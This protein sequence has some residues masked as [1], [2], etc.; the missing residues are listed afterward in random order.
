[1]TVTVDHVDPVAR[2]SCATGSTVPRRP[3]QRQLPGFSLQPY[4]RKLLRP[5]AVGRTDS[6]PGPERELMPLRRPSRVPLVV[7][8]REVDRG[9]ALRTVERVCRPRDSPP[10]PGRSERRRSGRS[11]RP[12]RCVCHRESRVHG[13]EP[14][15]RVYPRRAASPPR[16][17][18]DGAGSTAVARIDRYRSVPGGGEAISPPPG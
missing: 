9:G 18:D 8:R 4:D 3:R 11:V 16:A 1:M 2:R 7:G 12:H 15:V 14:A 6:R 13:V 5:P 10:S 17:R